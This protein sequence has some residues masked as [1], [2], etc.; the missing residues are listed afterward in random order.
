MQEWYRL[1]KSNGAV[2]EDDL[3]KDI[4]CKYGDNSSNL[5][6]REIRVAVDQLVEYHCAELSEGN[7]TITESIVIKW[8]NIFF[9]RRNAPT[10]FLDYYTIKASGGF[11]ATYS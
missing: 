8:E 10:C 1:P 7:L 11:Y 4:L 6:E 2:N 3:I 9:K 5:T